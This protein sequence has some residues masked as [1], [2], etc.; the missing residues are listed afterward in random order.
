MYMCIQHI[1]TQLPKQKENNHV[2]Q[3][4]MDS[5]EFEELLTAQGLLGY[6]S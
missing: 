2:L 6:P 1:G 4:A 5:G 3:D